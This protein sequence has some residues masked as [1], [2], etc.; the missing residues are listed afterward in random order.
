MN[1]S[2][3]QLRPDEVAVISAVGLMAGDRFLV[4]RVIDTGECDIADAKDI[5]FIPCGKQ[6]FL[7]ELHNPIQI[8]MPG[9]YRIVPDGIVSET[10]ALWVETIPA[11]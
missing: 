4:R 6:L 3:F 7:D 8:A 11:P 1:T 2:T 10:A 5:P 9:F